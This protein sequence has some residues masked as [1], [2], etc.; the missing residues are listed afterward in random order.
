MGSDV[1]NWLSGI[2]IGLVGILI[3]VI[4]GVFY[5]SKK[6]TV[7]KTYKNIVT[8]KNLKDSDVTVKDI[9]IGDKMESELEASK[10]KEKK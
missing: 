9:N 10:A 2:G 4:I 6:K 3:T 1:M 7:K 5:A 8:V